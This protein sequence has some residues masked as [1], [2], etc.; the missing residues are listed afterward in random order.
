M[1]R[2]TPVLTPEKLAL[3]E[4]MF[5]AGEEREEISVALCLYRDRIKKMMVDMPWDKKITRRN[6]W[7]ARRKQGK[8]F[9]RN[10]A[11]REPSPQAW[12][13]RDLRFS[14]PRTITA[15]RFGDPR[16]GQS[17]LDKMRA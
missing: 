4:E 10:F 1:P 12:A 16:Q 7:L 14:A 8:H 2:P 3:F 6:N 5:L 11:Q 17:A 13:D 9:V 15:E